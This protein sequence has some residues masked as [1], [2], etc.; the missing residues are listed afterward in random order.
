[1]KSEK[2]L[3]TL[4]LFFSQVN[5][6]NPFVSF[7]LFAIM[8]FLM[9]IV[10]LQGKVSLNISWVNF[11]FLIV[12]LLMAVLTGLLFFG[13][14]EGEIRAR[15][16]FLYASI[17]LFMFVMVVNNLKKDWGAFYLT[18]FFIYFVV[19]SLVIQIGRAHV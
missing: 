12:F 13:G 17:Q 11:L 1:M 5:Y 9:L 14:S 7:I 16:L 10:L 2:I 6:F 8:C 15:P 3:F 19:E 4:G 18:S